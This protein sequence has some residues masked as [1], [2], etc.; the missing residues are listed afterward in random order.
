MYSI[1]A[2]A[3]ATGLTVETL[4]AWERRYG[5]VVPDRDASGRRV[6]RPEDVLR[7]RRLRE[8]TE[9][10]HPIGR[11]AGLSEE[12]LAQL[13]DE[14]PDRRTRATSNAFV[15]RILGAAQHFRFADCEQTL[16]LAI[17]ML[18]PHQLVTDVLQPLL[19]EVG[20]RWHR[21]ELAVSQERLVST[22]VRRHLGLMLDAYDR[23][24]R[25]PPILFCTLPG[26]RHELGLLT[27]AMLCASRG[28]KT[29]YLGP[30]LPAEE[31]ARFAREVDA[32]VIALSAVLLTQV[33]NVPAQLAV[34]AAEL[35][36]TTAIWLGGPAA[37]AVPREALPA[38]CVVLRDESELEQRLEMLAV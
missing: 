32:A 33:P 21:G 22:T 35:P 26:E 7:L 31:I 13:L 17:A 4:R 28:F 3:Q 18:P 19:R 16:T 23:N 12:R 15:E 8:A 27:T 6:Y 36:S 9:R 1:K 14:S 20:D 25:R 11:L 2:V 30:E 34:L 5:V 38:Q 29:H 37:L 10:G 24:A